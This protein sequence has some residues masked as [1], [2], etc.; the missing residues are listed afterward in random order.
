MSCYFSSCLSERMETFCDLR[1][2]AG[3][4]Y[5]TQ[6]TRLEY[7]DRFLVETHF[8]GNS[9]TREVVDDY[10]NQSGH[11]KGRTKSQRLGIVRQFCLYLSQFEPNCYVPQSRRCPDHLSVR[12]PYIF[13]G[14]QIAI[15]RTEASQLGPVS[16]KRGATLS[17]LY[18]LLYITGLRIGEALGLN[19]VDFY[20]RSLR[21]F[22]AK[23]KFHKQRWVPLMPSTSA[24]LQSYLAT[25]FK[26]AVLVNTSPFFSNTWGHRLTYQNASL[27]F[28]QLLSQAG[29]YSAEGQRPHLH[30]LR[31]SFACNRLLSWYRQ[32]KNVN[33]LLPSLATYMG[34][35]NI[36]STQVYLH[37]TPELM[38]Q[39]YQRSLTYYRTHV[40]GSGRQS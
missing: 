20:P 10:L 8:Q 37:A 12:Q 16:T 14:E 30:D 25:R 36:A 7:F 2:L 13:T 22:V 17:T 9:P 21:L 18:G 4:D 29:I 31:H 39:A 5:Q 27:P 19:L 11:L 6:M 33:N 35:V 32:G 3:M 28:R 40:I 34:H 38:E 26:A 1:R 23:G 24:A 15:L